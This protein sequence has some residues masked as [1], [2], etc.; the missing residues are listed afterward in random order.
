MPHEFSTIRIV[1]FS[2]TDMAGIMHFSNYFRYME[3]T[4]HAFF[5]SLGLTL[6]E[7]GPEGSLGWARVSAE[8][9]YRRPLRYQDQVEVRLL[10]T[11]KR[12]RSIGYTFLFHRLEGEQPEEVARGTM[13][14][15]CVAQRRRG[16][17]MAAVPMPAAVDQAV[18][19][20]PEELRRRHGA[21]APGSARSPHA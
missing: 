6:H 8:C 1:E 7:E 15:V 17:E 10:V 16:A 14:V 21:G 9:S 13:T 3:A 19:V 4:E 11:S 18:Q 20:A 12:A 5:R 2:E